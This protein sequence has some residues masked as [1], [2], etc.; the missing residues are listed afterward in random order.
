MRRRIARFIFV[1]LL[2][3]LAMILGV[4]TSMTLTPPGRDLHLPEIRRQIRHAVAQRGVGIP[5]ENVHRG[6]DMRVGVDDTDALSHNMRITAVSV[7]RMGALC[8]NRAR[9]HCHGGG[10]KGCGV[11][12]RWH[13]DVSH[14]SQSFTGPR[15][16]CQPPSQSHRQLRDS[17]HR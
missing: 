13:R 14:R 8:A 12:V 7:A 3:T 4:V 1:T 5:Q 17:V 11:A 6:I 15:R 16:D 10:A 2:G 9:A